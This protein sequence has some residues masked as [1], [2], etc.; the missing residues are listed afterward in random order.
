MPGKPEKRET[1][2][3][4]DLALSNAYQFV[5]YIRLGDEGVAD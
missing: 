3:V 4:E 5:F 1:V 2:F